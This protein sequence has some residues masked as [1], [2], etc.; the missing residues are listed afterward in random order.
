MRWEGN[1]SP[2]TL[3]HNSSANK[4]KPERLVCSGIFRLGENSAFAERKPQD[5][6]SSQK[7]SGFFSVFPF[8][9]AVVYREKL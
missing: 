1:G 9:N 3:F 5:A 6:V 4:R 7:D 8:N 2:R